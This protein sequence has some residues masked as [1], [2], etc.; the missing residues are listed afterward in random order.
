[1]GRANAIVVGSAVLAP[2]LLGVEGYALFRPHHRPHAAEV[3]DVPPPALPQPRPV[4]AP[5]PAPP[6]ARRA[7]PEPTPPP[8]EETAPP[9]PAVE[10][11]PAP[12][13]VIRQRELLVRQR[14]TVRD[15]DERVFDSL[16]L[17]DAQ[18]TAIRAIDDQYVRAL[19]AMEQTGTSGEG[20]RPDADLNANQTRRA[21]I[22]NI[23]GAEG[24]H[25]FNF[26]ERKAERRVRSELRAQA[27]R[28]Q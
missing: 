25:T 16:N 23:L 17:P 13:T 6:P 9:E 4:V 27:L 3:A 14:Q 15:A 28:G 11:A 26:E 22:A 7:A 20:W 8:P 2:L 12:A 5:P 1:M 19:Q 18:R 21:A 10:A 24:M